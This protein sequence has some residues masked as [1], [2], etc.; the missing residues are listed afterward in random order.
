MLP[1]TIVG[2][3]LAAHLPIMLKIEFQITEIADL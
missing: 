2:L 3:N 1:M